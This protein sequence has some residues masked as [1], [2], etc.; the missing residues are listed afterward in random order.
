[1]AVLTARG[2]ELE[3]EFAWGVVRQLFDVVMRAPAGQRGE[4][5]EGAAALARPALGIE[6]A[7]SAVDVSYATLH[8]LYW[9]TVNLAQ[10]RPLLLAIDD[11]HWADRP[12]L[13]FVAHLLPRLSELP[14]LLLL[15]SR[16]AGAEPGPATELLARL[17]SEPALISL[18][19]AALSQTAS[20]ELVRDRLSRAASDDFCRACHEL[21]GGNPFLLGAL[22]A[23]LVGEGEVAGEALAEHLRRLTPATVSASV[24]LRLARLPEGAL[25]LARAVAILGARA[26][27]R[28]ARLLAQIEADE[29]A[30]AAGALIRAGILVEDET[31]GFVHPL[32]RSAVY[33]DLSGPE[34]SRWHQRTARLLA[35]DEAPLERIVSHLLESSPNG[36]AW[37]VQRLREGASE[38]W[39][40][41][42]PEIA[43]EYLRRALAEPPDAE[44]RADVLFELGQA[45]LVHDPSLAIEVLSEALDVARGAERRAEVALALGEALVLLGRAGEA[46]PILSA[47]IADLDPAG[48]DE[49]RAS[50]TA[51]QLSGARW[52]ASA[53]PLR[54][55]LVEAITRRAGAREPL[56]GRLHGQLAIEAAATGI[57]RA[58]AIK[59]A[60]AAL[61]AEERATGAATSVL[62][63]AMLVLVFADLVDEAREAIEGWL[64]LARARAWPLATA[65]GATVATLAALYRGE[66]S[67][68]VAS[69][70]GAVVPGAEV[71]LAPVSVGFLLGAL[72]ERGEYELA[73]AEL[74]E[75]GLGGDLPDVWATTPLLLARGRLHA[76]V[77][78]HS[79]AVGDLMASGE[80]AE[81]WG[82]R[83]PAMHPW[84]SSAAVSLAALGRHEEAI[85]LA[86]EEIELARR[87]GASRAIGVALRAGG[88]AHDGEEG[89]ELLRQAVSTLESSP[90]PLE[91]ARALADLGSA[92]RRGG[93]RA[94]AREHLRRSLD[95][96]HRLGGIA[97]ADRAREELRIAG[98][99]PRRDALRGRD[100]LTP[101][102]LRIAQLA[103]NGRTNRQIA[104]TLFLTLRTVET[105]LTSSYSKLNISSRRELTAALEGMEP[106][107][108]GE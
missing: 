12:S 89:L 85:P 97:V 56:D 83:N 60:R 65:F 77:G 73:H 58:A 33:G 69:A 92:L 20:G 63:E 98:A 23:D 24:L 74:K 64:A 22:V 76:A 82:V 3:R 71:R 15:A 78:D 29:A 45:K 90:A 54:R 50:L 86:Q 27:L 48:A 28:T 96:A 18:R 36:D 17:A 21:S 38:A 4:L 49:L 91:H 93:Q 1:M 11:A 53:Q 14:I 100:A 9:L 62:P 26:D 87:W 34:R 75:H 52:D 30:D 61:A 13:R 37:T 80:R 6:A 2:G 7:E 16:P 40:S 79:S 101:S 94:Q 41:G 81:A 55:E 103:A 51:T 39:A 104:E 46:I 31:L 19:P 32:V 43:A 8:G 68:A 44:A 106:R 10:R 95:L 5:L 67:E 108:G 57:D 102:E 25:A 66:V 42:A 105:H 99:R 84:R 72:T 59:H 70:R 35:E 107:Q 88:I 47:G